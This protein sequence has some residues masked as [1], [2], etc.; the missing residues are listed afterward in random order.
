[1]KI[2]IDASRVVNEKA[3]IGRYS[4][5]LIHN[6]IDQNPKDNFLLICNFVR[7]KNEKRGEMEKYRRG[8]VRI[9]YLKIPGKLKEKIWHSKLSIAQ[10]YLEDSDVYLALTFLDVITNLKIPQAVVIHDLTTFKYPDHLGKKL[11]HYFN[12]QTL[13][14]CTLAAKIIAISKSTKNDLIDILKIPE[15]K[16]EV[17]Y[18][19]QNKFPEMAATLP[20]GLKNQGYILAVG[21][22]EPRKNLTGLLEA[23]ALLPPSLSEKYPLVIAGGKGWNAGKIFDLVSGLHLEDKTKFLG[24]ISDKTLARLYHEAALFV[25]PSLYEGFGLP[26]LEAQ[27]FGVP[28]VTSNVSSLPEVVGESGILVDPHDL[29]AL[30][31]AIQRLLENKTEAQKLGEKGLKQAKKFSNEISA[32]KVSQILKSLVK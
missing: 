24:F 1:M 29:Q 22:L 26:V 7:H 14:A 9:K 32:R 18:P 12:R 23:Y 15:N 31:S 6:L 19:G 5:N 11:S 13:Q 30:T 4:A 8:N 25:Y 10:K 28:V 17:I 21:T 20:A 27:S 16:I 3:G 2:A